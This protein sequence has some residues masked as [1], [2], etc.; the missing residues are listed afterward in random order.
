V[1]V[2]GGEFTAEFA[3]EVRAR[4]VTGAVISMLPHD[5]AQQLARPRSGLPMLGHA[6]TSPAITRDERGESITSTNSNHR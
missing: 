6:P 5:A 4:F 3:V 2:A 1:S